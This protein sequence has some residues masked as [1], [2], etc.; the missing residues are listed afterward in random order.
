HASNARDGSAGARVD[1]VRVVAPAGF[2]KILVIAGSGNG[3]VAK[4][5]RFAL[6]NFDGP[7]P[8]AE[9]RA[10]SPGANA[11]GPDPR[12]LKRLDRLVDGKALADPADVDGHAVAR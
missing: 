7:V 3:L 1:D 4:P 2:E 6:F 11:A 12:G 8:L 10:V 5:D 9:G